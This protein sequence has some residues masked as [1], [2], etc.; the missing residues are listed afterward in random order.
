MVARNHVRETET[1]RSVLLRVISERMW[2]ALLPLAGGFV[3]YKTIMYFFFSF[4]FSAIITWS[5]ILLPPVIIKLFFKKPIS[6]F[7]S[8]LISFV[9]LLINVAIFI[10]ITDGTATGKPAAI[11]ALFTYYILRW[12][13]TLNLP[14]LQV[15]YLGKKVL[16]ITLIPFSILLFCILIT[17]VYLSYEAYSEEDIAM[18]NT[19]CKIVK[20]LLQDIHNNDDIEPASENDEPFILSYSTSTRVDKS[21]YNS[22]L[23]SCIYTIRETTNANIVKEDCGEVT[24]E[25]IVEDWRNDTDMAGEIE[26]C[27]NKVDSYKEIIISIYKFNGNE[28]LG[29]YD[30]N[31]EVEKREYYDMIE[32]YQ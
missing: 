22:E 23:D 21:F 1:L 5:I 18:K 14:K 2:V 25:T 26:D 19:E 24:I 28:L 20:E 27:E 7:K 15:K 12:N 29:E 6:K 32:L 9:L 8:V 31:N 30:M 17:W 10:V 3:Y 13:N 16:L 11:G 4:L